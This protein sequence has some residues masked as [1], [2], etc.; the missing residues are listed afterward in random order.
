MNTTNYWEKRLEHF[1]LE[2]YFE[3][4]PIEEFSEKAVHKSDKMYASDELLNQ[5]HTIAPSNQAKYMVLLAVLGTLIQ[6]TTDKKEALICT[7]LFSLKEESLVFKKTI[8]VR[9]LNTNDL[10]F[11]ELLMQLTN[12][13]KGDFKQGDSLTDTIWKT[14]LN[15]SKVGMYMK[16]I[17]VDNFNQ[18]NY[19]DL[20]FIFSAD[21]RL[22]L[23]IKCNTNYYN[24]DY[25]KT[26]GQRYFILLKTILTE[27][28]KQLKDCLL[29][30]ED[31]EK[32]LKSFNREQK[33]KVYSKN[34][35]E[36]FEKQVLK[37]P[38]NLAVAYK[39]NQLSYEELNARANQL[40]NYLIKKGLKKG[41]MVGLYLDRSVET[42]IGL[43]GVLKAGG[44][45][46]P[47]SSKFP[48]ERVSYMLEKGEVA[49]LLTQ[50]DLI[51]SFDFKGIQVSI[52]SI[53]VLEESSEN[54][55]VKK[56][57]EESAYCIF[58]SGSTGTPKGVLVS[59]KSVINLVDG[60]KETIYDS[61]PNPLRVALLASH[62]FDASVQQIFG[63]LLQGHSIY[64]ASQE[65]CSDGNNLLRF[66]QENKIQVSDGTPTHFRLVVRELNA[67]HK[68]D[69]FKVWILAGEELPKKITARFFEIV[70]DNVKI[71][72]MYGP[73]ETCVD[74]TY[75]PL[76]NTTINAYSFIPIGKPL[77]NE[78]IYITD[79][80]GNQ[81]PVGIVGEIVIAG[82]GLAKGYLKDE[83]LTEE[84]FKQHWLKNEV[85][86]YKTGDL[87]AWMP[88]GKLKFIGRKD[89]QIKLRGYRIEFGDIEN[90]IMSFD[91]VKE[92]V[93]DLREYKNEPCLVAYYVPK[94]KNIITNPRD[95]LINKLPEYMIPSYFLELDELPL[96][97]S[98]K[99][100]KKLLPDPEIN[101]TGEHKLPENDTEEKLLSIWSD[102]LNLEKEK[103]ST[104]ASFMALGG[105]SLMA[106]QIANQIKKSF[107]IQ[108]T[109]VELFQQAT[110]QQ[111][112]RFIEANSWLKESSS[113][114]EETSKLDIEI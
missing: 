78:Q 15:T 92:V 67:D 53:K 98:G 79:G 30:T 81:M 1:E 114:M 58:T 25:I 46:L 28:D 18:L 6:K 22:S 23:D 89:S 93:V 31:E 5:L 76:T 59:D 68:L 65:E 45:Y 113:T 29:I 36:L 56:S 94:E 32:D 35:C 14:R 26:I 112:A 75:Y 95:F 47:M 12:S 77:P 41:E 48:D 107:E 38:K 3:E 61:L 20:Q 87:G 51:V 21:D 33:E 57:A 4:V 50:E 110:I 43:L 73:T 27:K 106:I 83:V 99:L 7:P 86:V 97:T 66:Y 34:L 96:T 60:L 44:V 88:D 90:T 16:Q 104:N 55:A 54:I 108:I 24:F 102:V 9:I 100:N 52:N 42:I 80:Y 109:L 40:A 70:Q 101:I 10:T 2:T 103:I 91:A 8:P 62:V 72:N 49:I 13:L 37:S 17:Q 19:P 84:K 85:R 39:Q 63:G 11:K 74:S 64:I 71:Y 105:H 69:H 111:Q 82:D